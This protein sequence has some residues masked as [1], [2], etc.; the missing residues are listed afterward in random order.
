MVRNAGGRAFAL[1]AFHRFLDCAGPRG[2][3]ADPNRLPCF[4]VVMSSGFL[5]F[6]SVLWH[7]KLIS[8]DAELRVP[9]EVRRLLNRRKVTERQR[10]RA[11]E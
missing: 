5:E 6:G 7:F 10:A 2:V 1:L 9:V 3:K 11:R 4:M 8:G